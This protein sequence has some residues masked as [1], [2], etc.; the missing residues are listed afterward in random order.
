MTVVQTKEFTWDYSE[1]SDIV[2]IHRTGRKVK[3][4]TELGDFTV[5]FDTEGNIVG[6]EIMNVNS[7]L[8]EAG[9]SQSEL[10]QLQSAE[11]IV[12]Q[13]KANVTYIWI[14]FMFPHHIEKKIPIPVPV[15]MEV[16]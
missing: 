13:G 12:T 14:K 10:T 2:N 3:E 7:F 9:I 6:I 4:S 15:M 1:R 16:A 11:L 5:D 8:K